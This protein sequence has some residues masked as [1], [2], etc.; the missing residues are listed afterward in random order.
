[1]VWVHSEWSSFNIVYFWK[2]DF[3]YLNICTFSFVFQVMPSHILSC[4]SY[5][6]MGITLYFS[7][8]KDEAISGQ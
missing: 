3:P 4:Y 2:S 5:Q 7:R 1:L 8:G 6:H